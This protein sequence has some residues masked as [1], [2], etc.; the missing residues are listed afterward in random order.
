MTYIRMTD[1]RDRG[2]VKDFPV[3]EAQEMI[4]LG[5]ALPV[6]FDKSDTLGFRELETPMNELQLREVAPPLVPLPPNV[7][8]FEPSETVKREVISAHRDGKKKR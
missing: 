6:N 8:R 1:G 3:P 4:A 7:H 2:Y 5:Q